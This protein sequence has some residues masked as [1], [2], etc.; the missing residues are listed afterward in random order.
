[1]SA[2]ISYD[3]IYNKK[4]ITNEETFSDAIVYMIQIHHR[5]ELKN[6]YFYCMNLLLI[7]NNKIGNN[8]IAICYKIQPIL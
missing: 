2:I 1:M 4:F 7:G 6:M 5:M 3:S 8:K